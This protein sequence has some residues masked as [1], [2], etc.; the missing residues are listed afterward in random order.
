MAK[1]AMPQVAPVAPAAVPPAVTAYPDSVVLQALED[2]VL[3]PQ[4]AVP[5]ESTPTHPPTA[6]AHPVAPASLVSV[7]PAETATG[8][9]QPS[10]EARSAAA[11]EVAPVAATSVGAA[12]PVAAAQEAAVVALAAEGVAAAHSPLQPP[13]P[14]P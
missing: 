8:P 4:Q 12:P 5:V 14:Q 1:A 7:V 13:P 2:R 9:T 11:Q 3:V 10:T 6:V